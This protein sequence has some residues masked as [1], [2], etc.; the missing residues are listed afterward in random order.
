MLLGLAGVT[1]ASA[2]A[3]ATDAYVV[4]TDRPGMAQILARA[5]VGAGFALGELVEEKADL[6]H[7]FLDL[8][9][10]AVEQIAA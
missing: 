2:E 6:E 9:R 4:E 5:V 10:R 1:G 8:T 3:A 7:V